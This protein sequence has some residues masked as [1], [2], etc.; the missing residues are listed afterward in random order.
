[1]SNKPLL[2]VMSAL[3]A[4]KELNFEKGHV[5]TDAEL[6]AL[7]QVCGEPALEQLLKD[8]VFKPVYAGAT[9]AP[10]PDTGP[11]DAEKAAKA[12]AEARAKEEAKAAKEAEKAEKAA[13]AKA[14]KDA[15]DAE[16]AAKK[17]AKQA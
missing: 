8:G 2:M 3:S 15:K 14:A 13:A 4:S 1:M 5:L 9:D 7:E 16:K 17:A 6:K 11:S 12:E 10:A